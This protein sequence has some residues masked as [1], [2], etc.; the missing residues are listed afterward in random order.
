MA[1]TYRFLGLQGTVWDRWVQA[2]NMFQPNTDAPNVQK[3]VAGRISFKVTFS[4]FSPQIT[5]V[6]LELL[7][8]QIKR[9]A[10]GMLLAKADYDY[11]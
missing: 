5:P 10:D 3:I 1:A 11:T 7:S 4:E 2:I 9:A 6:T 8:V